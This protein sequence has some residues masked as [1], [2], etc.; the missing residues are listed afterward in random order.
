MNEPTINDLDIGARVRLLRQKKKQTQGE[1]ATSLGVSL[2]YYSKLE[3][4]QRNFSTHLINQLANL[5][6]VSETWLI[7]GKGEA[8]AFMVKEDRAKYSARVETLSPS[9]TEQFMSC[10]NE[11]KSVIEIAVKEYK[12]PFAKAIEPAIRE[13]EKKLEARE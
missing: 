11:K 7:S 3:L 6:G 1:L 2:S 4:G 10:L 13:F 12:I 5:H 9:W 8:G